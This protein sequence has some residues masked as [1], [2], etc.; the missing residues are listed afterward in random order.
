[1]EDLIQKGKMLFCMIFSIGLI[2]MLNTV[3]IMIRNIDEI[4][5][6]MESKMIRQIIR[7]LRQKRK[8]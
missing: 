3:K 6:E 4:S 7:I 1:M 2:V 5:N 8:K